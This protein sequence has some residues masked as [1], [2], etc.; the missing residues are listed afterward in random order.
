MPPDKFKATWLSHSSISDFQKCPRLYYYRNVYKD[1]ITGHKITRAQPALALG[2]AVHDVIESLSMLPVE[3]RFSISP[4]KKF[5]VVWE[6]NKGKKGGFK[7]KEEEDIFYE[8]GREMI[9]RVIDNPG[10]LLNKA[11]KISQ[12]LPYFW[13]NEEEN[14]ILCGKVD[15]L[16]YLPQTDSVHIIDF[17]TGRNEEEDDSMQLPIYNLLVTNTQKRN[18]EKASYWYLTKDNKPREVEL[19]D[20]KESHSKIYDI[21]KRIRLARQIEHFSCPRG[22]CI[23]CNPMEDIAKGKGELIGE[24]RYRHDIYIL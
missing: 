13:L 14:I 12:E 6:N 1:P 21:G 2:G 18:V 22:G 3:E 19:P 11:V 9:Q 17:K 15:W 4:L 5:D 10:P 23:F 8:R 20:L 16:E 7:S 24:D